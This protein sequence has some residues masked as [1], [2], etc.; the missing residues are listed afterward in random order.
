M[1][2]NMP[3]KDLQTR[4]EIF[5]RECTTRLCS[6]KGD[7]GR[8]FFVTSK[9]HIGIGPI[10]P[11]GAC[12]GNDVAVLTTATTPFILRE[13]ASLE[14]RKERRKEKIYQA[15]ELQKNRVEEHLKPFGTPMTVKDIANI[16]VPLDRPSYRVV[17]G[18]YYVHGDIS[19]ILFQAESRLELGAA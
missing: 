13:L 6:S 2:P 15:R 12:V 16:D 14:F 3:S 9:G 17:V 1:V 10:G 8:S 11:P 4:A 18:N 19:W 7:L 5:Q